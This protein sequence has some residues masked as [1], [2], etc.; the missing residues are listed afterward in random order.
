MLSASYCL[1]QKIAGTVLDYS[2]KEVIP[3]THVI[4]N[5]TNRGTITNENGEF[6]IAVSHRQNQSLNISHIGYHPKTLP[7]NELTEEPLK[8]FLVKSETLLDEVVFKADTPEEILYKA[9]QNI[10]R[11][12]PKEPTIIRGFYREL[13]KSIQT[14][15]LLYVAEG[16][17]DVFKKNYGKK[18]PSGLIIPLKTRSRTLPALSKFSTRFYSGPHAPH[19][20]DFVMRK[21]EFI[22]PRLFEHYV[23]QLTDIYDDPDGS[24][25][26]ISFRPR[27]SSNASYRGKIYVA[28]SSFAYLGAS[29]QLTDHG[30]KKSNRDLNQNFNWYGRYY[31]VMYDRH[32]DHYYLK[33]TFD[34][35][36]G[37]T[38]NT[39]DSVLS[40]SVFSTSK[41]I[42]DS[43]YI[44]KS[45]KLLG[46]GEVF[47]H[48]IDSFDAAF[49]KDYTIVKGIRNYDQIFKRKAESK[50]NES[51][52]DKIFRF[53]KRINLEY[54]LG[55]NYLSLDNAVI[56]TYENESF[57]DAFT[58]SEQR[59][60]FPSFETTVTYKF[61]AKIEV[62]WSYFESLTRTNTAFNG[63]IGRYNF[64]KV[65]GRRVIRFSPS[66]AVGYGSIGQ[67]IANQSSEQPFEV[68]GKRVDASE[69]SL[70]LVER[71]WALVPNLTVS[72]SIRR[73]DLIVGGRTHHP[74][75]SQDGLLIKEKDGFFLTRKNAFENSDSQRLTLS[76]E[77]DLNLN[78]SFFVGIRIS[79]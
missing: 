2:S 38:N 59:T 69:V 4:V 41:V 35:S 20:F 71:G 52:R 28:D 67:F 3:F 55:Y 39:Q 13:V 45:E 16:V 68:N 61:N 77:P 37:K 14:D 78:F 12:Y 65:M 25:Y 30:L 11:N 53:L 56:A 57:S 51:R 7:L 43:L 26:E 9:Y 73:F 42:T 63:F 23:Y 46:Y 74:F 27:S 24:K 29:Y 33:Y 32:L 36:Y 76:A 49:W 19:K 18:N 6:E 70:H 72:Y 5:N 17:M 22:N 58:I 44:P 10:A 21:E 48:A 64:A 50:N 40:S 60:V 47:L 79:I 1:S 34:E 54:G 15:S 8:I 75:R 31:K 62:G 66:L